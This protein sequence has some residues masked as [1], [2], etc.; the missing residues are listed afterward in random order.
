MHTEKT[1]ESYFYFFSTLLKFEPLLSNIVAFGTDGE[2]AIVKA[3]KAIFPT[4]VHLRCFVHMKENIRRK[5]SDLLL[6]E[7]ARQVILADIFGSQQGNIYIKGL[8]DSYDPSDF[9][10][11][12]AA[13]EEKWNDLEQS[14]HPNQ[15]AQFLQWFVDN[16]AGC[17]CWCLYVNLLA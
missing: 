11:R 3:L 8:V 14:A 1:Y 4:T 9:D 7:S 10:A 12:M 15:E 17:P 6:P 2:Q 13:V 16:K 5:L